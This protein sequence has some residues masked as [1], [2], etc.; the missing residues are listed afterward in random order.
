LQLAQEEAE[1]VIQ[2]VPAANDVMPSAFIVAGLDLEEQQYVSFQSFFDTTLTFP[3]RR[4]KIDMELKIAVTSKQKADLIEW[5]LKL[6]HQILCFRTLQA[7][8]M[9]L[10]WLPPLN[11]LETVEHI[12]LVL[13]S[14]LTK[15]GWATSCCAGLVEIELQFHEAQCCTVL[16]CLQ[17]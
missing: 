10:V 13:P 5:R 8:Y 17:N 2:G 16:D 4:I 3:R 11:D 12:P 15:K 9:P 7:I 14:V 1:S 6:S